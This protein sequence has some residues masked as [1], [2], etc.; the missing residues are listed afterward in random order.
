MKPDDT[1]N[2]DGEAFDVRVVEKAQ[3]IEIYYDASF[4][5]QFEKHQNVLNALEDY[6]RTLDNSDEK[7]IEFY[8]NTDS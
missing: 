3:S 8:A 7:T 6:A 1:I 4:E 5:D 2:I